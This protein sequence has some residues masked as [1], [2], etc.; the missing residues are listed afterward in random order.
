LARPAQGNGNNPDRYGSRLW[1]LQRE[2]Q[3]PSVLPK[4]KAIIAESVAWSI[5]DGWVSSLDISVSFPARGWFAY[6]VTAHKP[7]GTT[8]SFGQQ[9]PWG[10]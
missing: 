8:T 3:L 9:V 1:L 2:R 10:L 5:E 6:Q 4:A 7:D